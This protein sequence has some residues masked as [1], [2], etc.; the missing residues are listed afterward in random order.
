[1]IDLP[2]ICHLEHH[3]LEYDAPTEQGLRELLDK[4]GG[5]RKVTNDTTKK[6]YKVPVGFLLAHSL[7]ADKLD[8]YGFT[9][10]T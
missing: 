10:W 6:S 2:C 8:T 3:V 4:N 9:P 5:F 7:E 1:M